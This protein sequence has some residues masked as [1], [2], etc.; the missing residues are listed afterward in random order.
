MV[1]FK[2]Q[3]PHHAY[4]LPQQRISVPDSVETRCKILTIAPSWLEHVSQYRTGET[5]KQCNDSMEFQT[6]FS[7]AKFGT[8]A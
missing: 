3:R 1:Y 8:G 4:F 6:F 5:R 2:C 7:V